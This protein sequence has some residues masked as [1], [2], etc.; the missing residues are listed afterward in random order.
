MQITRTQDEILN[1]YHARKDRGEHS[2]QA[3]R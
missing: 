3:R 1:Q 2:A